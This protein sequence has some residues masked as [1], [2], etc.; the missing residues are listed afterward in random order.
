MSITDT[1]AHELNHFAVQTEWTEEDRELLA[2][3]ALLDRPSSANDL[4]EILKD[5]SLAH[6]LFVLSEAGW[7]ARDRE[8]GQWSVAN[9]LLGKQVLAEMKEEERAALEEKIGLVLAKRHGEDPKALYYLSHSPNIDTARQAA[10]GAYHYHWDREEYE[11]ALAFLNRLLE[12]SQ[13]LPPIQVVRFK[14]LKSECLSALRQFDAAVAL[15]QSC[16]EELNSSPLDEENL[17]QRLECL[18]KLGTVHLKQ[19]Q[20]LEATEAYQTGLAFS[21]LL[22]NGAVYKIYFENAKAHVKVQEGQLDA[23][24]VTFEKTWPLWEKLGKD[25]QNMVLNNDLGR[26]L[27]MLGRHEAALEQLKVELGH[28]NREQNSFCAARTYYHLADAHLALKHF[29]EAVEHYRSGI[30]I[31]KAHRTYDLLVR[32]YN[33]LGN[34][35]QLRQ[36]FSESIAAYERA[37]RYTR[38]IRETSAMA[39]VLTNLGILYQRTGKSHEAF[40][41]LTCAIHLIS[42][43]PNRRAY[44][45]YCLARS[46]LELGDYY[47]DSKEYKKSETHLR[48]ALVLCTTHEGIGSLLPWVLERL[49]RT[50][51][52]TGSQSEE[53]SE[54]FSLWEKA[55][56]KVKE[57]PDGPYETL[58]RKWLSDH[59]FGP[60]AS[61]AKPSRV[62]DATITAFTSELNEIGMGDEKSPERIEEHSLIMSTGDEHFFT[63]KEFETAYIAQTLFSCRF[64]ITQAAKQLDLTRATLYRKIGEYHLEALDPLSFSINTALRVPLGSSLKKAMYSY[65]RESLNRYAVDCQQIATRL[66]V[67]RNRIDRLLE[68]GKSE[69]W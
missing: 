33:G 55:D 42:Q 4:V 16:L 26:T 28:Y 17:G 7:I 34:L 22:K 15:L 30:G 32:L 9:P 37:L 5:E 21:S 23:A 60:E 46:H 57:N 3:L 59:G 11:E 29:D 58:Y 67:S 12:L 53:I 24:L 13:G 56:P 2:V 10:E 39:G 14:M 38:K 47:L 25:E 27:L 1:I 63:W 19:N 36:Q 45:L 65:L 52:K 61:D 40:S 50:A 41:H 6:R 64:N 35:Y 18:K 69:G 48:E 68:R 43:L 49:V 62:D 8:T 20:I 66:G 51:M 54:W 44:E 31:A